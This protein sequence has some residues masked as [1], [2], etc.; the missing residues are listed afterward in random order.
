MAQTSL[1]ADMVFADGYSTQLGTAG[2]S[3]EAGMTLRAQRG[4]VS[5]PTTSET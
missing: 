3:P 1:A 2:G 4:G 5:G